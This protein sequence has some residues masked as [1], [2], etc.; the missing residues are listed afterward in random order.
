MVP[1]TPGPGGLSGL[2]GPRLPARHAPYRL[3][4]RPSRIGRAPSISGFSGKKQAGGQTFSE[5]PLPI[6]LVKDRI[7]V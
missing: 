1:V 5:H 7:G 4:K 2:M 3:C 6:P